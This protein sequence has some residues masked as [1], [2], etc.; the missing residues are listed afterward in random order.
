M[1]IIFRFLL[2]DQRQSAGRHVLLIGYSNLLFFSI[3]TTCS[4]NLR[5]FKPFPSLSP[6]PPTSTT[7]W[8]QNPSQPSGATS[9]SGTAC[10]I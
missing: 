6:P 3:L 10:P 9:R 2:W 7:P 8:K 1:L 4:T 5:P